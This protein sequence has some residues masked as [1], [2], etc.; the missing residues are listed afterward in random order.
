[1]DYNIHMNKKNHGFTLIELMVTLAVF[2][3]LAAFAAPNVSSF[4]RN[5][6]LGTQTNEFISALHITRSEAVKRGEVITLCISDGASPP[7]CDSTS[8]SW[9][10]GWIIF[11]DLNG[12]ASFNNASEDLVRIHEALTDDNTLTSSHLEGVA[13]N[14]QFT[15]TGV[16]RARDADSSTSPTR[17]FTLC[18]SYTDNVKRAKGINI[19]K[20]GN[21]SLAV[22]TNSNITVNNGV[23]SN[24][25]TCP[26]ATK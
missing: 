8:V 22:D 12:D 19:S 16:L 21:I 18:D 2:G 4:M 3:L 1:M 24:D 23:T 20:L 25:V 7:N 26:A 15:P 17:T 11:T 13:Y 10:A 6:R 9:Q 5:N 14:V